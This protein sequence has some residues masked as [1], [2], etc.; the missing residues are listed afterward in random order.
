MVRCNA[1]CFCSNAEF[2][3][4]WLRLSE[5]IDVAI[6]NHVPRTFNEQFRSV[7]DPA[8]IGVKRT[9]LGDRERLANFDC[10]QVAQVVERSPEKAGVGGSTPSLATTFSIT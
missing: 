5:L 1:R 8:T 6:I 10:G 2:A 4:R 3:T 7:A 9:T